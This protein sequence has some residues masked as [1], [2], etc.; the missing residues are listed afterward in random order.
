MC[1][2]RSKQLVFENG[3]TKWKMVPI[4]FPGDA[5][6]KFTDECMEIGYDL[7]VLAEGGVGYGTYILWAPT[8]QYNNFMIREVYENEWSS[9]YLV[10]QFRKMS[11]ALE[12]E[13]VALRAAMC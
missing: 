11:K 9:C 10:E 4:R 1:M 2:I 8:E 13:V 3:T 5:V 12:K 6:R 7:E